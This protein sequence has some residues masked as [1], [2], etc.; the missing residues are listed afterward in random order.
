M[1]GGVGKTII[2]TVLA[3]LILGLIGGLYQRDKALTLALQAQET[4]TKTVVEL[5]TTIKDLFILLKENTKDVSNLSG[6]IKV[7]QA[8]IEAL[9]R[10]VDRIEGRIS[11]EN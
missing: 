10:D 7:N 9:R 4:Q 1:V 2:T 3:A 5:K 8:Q 6:Q 11:D